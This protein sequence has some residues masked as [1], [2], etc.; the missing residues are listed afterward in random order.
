MFVF[1]FISMVFYVYHVFY[2]FPGFV[3]IKMECLCVLF[4]NIYINYLETNAITKT[5]IFIL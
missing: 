5:L 3:Y 1:F 4:R 2:V